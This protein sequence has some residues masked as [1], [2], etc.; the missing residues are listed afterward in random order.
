[1]TSESDLTD[2]P[3]S[4]DDEGEAALV[5]AMEPLA[6]ALQ[7]HVRLDH[8]VDIEFRRDDGVWYAQSTDQY[9]TVPQW[10]EE[11]EKNILDRVQQPVLDVGA[12]SGRHALLL[13]Q[14][15]QQVTAIDSSPEC[16]ELMRNRGVYDART[17]DIF[18]LE[19]GSWHS[20]L[21][22]METIG[23]VGTIRLLEALLSHLHRLVVEDGQILLDARPLQSDGGCGEYEG[24]LELQMRYGELVGEVFRWL[25]IDFD[26]LESVA[27]K[28][29]WQ[30][31]LI[32]IDHETEAYAVRLFK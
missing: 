18:E 24:E 1:M 8:S 31:Q 29:G 22:M 20:V 4:G 27:T 30:T 15:L 13:Q 26:M 3:T 6:L 2:G 5:S 21:F 9:F 25:Y 17:V 12:A 32:G 19:T 10:L 16:V 7:D 11:I 28:C 23:L 14:R